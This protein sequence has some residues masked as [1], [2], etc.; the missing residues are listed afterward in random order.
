MNQIKYYIN[1]MKVIDDQYNQIINIALNVSLNSFVTVL[2]V[3]S[4]QINPHQHSTYDINLNG[5]I[6]IQEEFRQA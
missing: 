3:F 2:K 5:V 1:N 4:G 6:I